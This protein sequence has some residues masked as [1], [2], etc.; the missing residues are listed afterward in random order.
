MNCHG[1]MRKKQED[2]QE[3]LLTNPVGCDVTDPEHFRIKETQQKE[4]KQ[5]H[6][7]TR[8]ACPALLATF[9]PFT[10]AAQIEISQNNVTRLCVS[11]VNSHFIAL[12]FVFELHL[13]I[14][15]GFMVV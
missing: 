9:L 11:A 2:K 12:P 8:Q 15:L 5:S 7:L 3:E 10:R 14:C 13:S 1:L 4:G 6:P